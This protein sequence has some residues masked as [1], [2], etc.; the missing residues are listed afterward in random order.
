MEDAGE[1]RRILNVILSGWLGECENTNYIRLESDTLERLIC[2]N[3]C[4]GFFV[5][6]NRNQVNYARTLYAI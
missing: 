2:F 3:L 5:P 6:P 1:T 4:N